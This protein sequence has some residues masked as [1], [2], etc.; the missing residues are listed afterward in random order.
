MMETTP[1]LDRPRAIRPFAKFL[2]SSAYCLNVHC[3]TLKCTLNKKY[4]PELFFH[5]VVTSLF[6][7]RSDGRQEAERS[8]LFKVLNFQAYFPLHPTIDQ[9]SDSKTQ[10]M[11]SFV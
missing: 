6:P 2:T 8:Q 7:L 9:A 11:M 5:I 1:N 3:R 4:F 10:E